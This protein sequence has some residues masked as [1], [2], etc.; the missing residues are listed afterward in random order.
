[1]KLAAR[2]PGQCGYSR[3][4][5]VA[6]LRAPQPGDELTSQAKRSGSAS[7]TSHEPAEA[8]G[9]SCPPS[10]RAQEWRRSGCRTRSQMRGR[11]F[12]AVVL[13]Q[14]R[15][16]QVSDSDAGHGACQPS[17]SKTSSGLLRNTRAA[18]AMDWLRPAPTQ[19]RRFPCS[20][21]RASAGNPY[22]STVWK[23]GCN[24]FPRSKVALLRALSS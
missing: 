15:T 24:S 14:P 19:T 10:S 3:N 8:A 13:G 9:A 11:S 4:R 7:C 20:L 6:A 17:L 1:V 18:W 21:I 12:S 23:Y 16:R 5:A 2:F 22:S